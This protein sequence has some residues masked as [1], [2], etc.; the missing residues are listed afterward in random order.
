MFQFDYQSSANSFSYFS[1]HPSEP[2]SSQNLLSGRLVALHLGHSISKLCPHSLQ[3]LAPSRFS[4]WHFGHFIFSP[5]GL[6][7]IIEGNNP[8]ENYFND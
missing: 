2:H 4:N 6:S 7:L 3:N 1:T 5:Q 8:N